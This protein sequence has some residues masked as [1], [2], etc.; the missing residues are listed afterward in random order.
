MIPSRFVTPVPGVQALILLALCA[1]AVT[2]IARP[3]PKKPNIVLILA[4]DLGYGDLSCYNDMAKV[5]TPHLDRL[6]QQGM[7]FTDA[8]SPATVC[9]PTRYSLM[10]G[11]MAFRVPNGSTVFTGVG[12]PSL[13][14]PDRLT[15]PDMLRE[16]GY[17]TACVGKWHLG[18]TFFDQH[19]HPVVGN[20]VEAVSKV[21]FSRSIVGGP[22]DHGFASFFGTACCPTT[23]WL[24]AFIKGD[25]V[26]IPPSMPLDRS[27]LPRHAYAND[28]RP[29]LIAPDFLLEEVDL[30]FLEKSREFLVNHR[31]ASPHQPF[32]LFHSTQ[33]V[34][35]PSFPATAFQGTTACGPHGD[36]IH[37]LD[38][39]VGELLSTIDALGIEG[40]TLVI[41]TSDNGPE[42][43]SVIH[44]RADHDHDGARPWRGV[45]R[46]SWEG[47]HRVPLL[48]RWP[49][50]IDAGSV[51][52]ET[53]C[54]TD[55]MA[56]LAEILGVSLPHDAAEDSFSLLP[57]MDGRQDI[58]IRP[59][60]ITQAFGGERTLSIRRGIWKYL[61]HPGSGGNRYDE[62]SPIDPGYRPDDSPAAL[63]DLENDP[64]ERRNLL[65]EHP[66]IVQEMKRLLEQSKKSGRSRPTAAVAAQG[67]VRPEVSEPVPCLP[68]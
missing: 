57:A 67:D 21:D 18:L 2:A 33:A 45:K 10:T 53:V 26:P 25:R 5:P 28:C 8:H 15:L 34:H 16:N 30:V 37:Q 66:R 4:D 14:A 27:S 35:L 24:Y 12:G 36:F 54:L 62:S 42:V 23:D 48:M 1:H 61:D 38:H 19:G 51:S 39:I 49:G 43:T 32:F 68:P 22:L 46:D 64:G 50:R 31:R 13:I 52:S 65:S 59:Y 41:F 47:G 55:L 11:Q 20:G 6:A 60:L 56:T 40:E 7:R 63:F 9:T 17:A 3:V 29:G 44:M 58:S